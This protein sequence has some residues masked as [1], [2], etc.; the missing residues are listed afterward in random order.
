MTAQGGTY[1]PILALVGAMYVVMCVRVASRMAHI[2]RNGAAWFFI[3]FFCTALP[4]AVVLRR[5]SRQ[6]RTAP[7]ANGGAPARCRH[8]GAVLGAAEPADPP[9]CHQCGMKLDEEKLA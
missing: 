7:R 1:W 5:H 4:A 6:G 2:G 9:V 8:C 3:S